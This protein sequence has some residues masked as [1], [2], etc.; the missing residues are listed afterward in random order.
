MKGNDHMTAKHT[1]R[2][3]TARRDGTE[4]IIESAYGAADICGI[5]NAFQGEDADDGEEATDNAHARLITAAPRMLDEL[6]KVKT[7]CE[8]NRRE[9]SIIYRPVCD[10]IL[11]AKGNA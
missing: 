9:C 11:Q 3:W 5:H 8:L 1:P 7:W 4:I 2:R 10:A 6:E